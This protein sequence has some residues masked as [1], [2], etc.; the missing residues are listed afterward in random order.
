MDKQMHTGENVGPTC[1]DPT[2]HDS[3][4]EREVTKT[5]R[6]IKTNVLRFKD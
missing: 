5:S 3:W 6:R 2:S 4:A 1:W